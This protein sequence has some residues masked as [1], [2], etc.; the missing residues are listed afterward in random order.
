LEGAQFKHADY[1]EKCLKYMEDYPDDYKPF[2]FDEEWGDYLRRMRKDGEWGGNLELAGIS[3][4]FGVHITIHQL[5]QPRWEVRN[6]KNSFSRMIHLSYHDGQHYASVRN[7]S[8]DIRKEATEVKA[9][10]NGKKFDPATG[11]GVDSKS[12][13]TLKILME[14]TG[15]KNTKFLGEALADNSGDV[16]ATIEYLISMKEAGLAEFFIVDGEDE[17]KEGKPVQKEEKK[18]KPRR[19]INRNG[20]CHCGSGKKYKTCCAK[21]DKAEAKKKRKDSMSPSRK[22]KGGKSV[23]LQNLSNKQRKELAK[24]AKREK[25]KEDVKKSSKPNKKKTSGKKKEEDEGEEIVDLGSL[26]I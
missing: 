18:S 7:L 3:Q 25:G 12:D 15:C 1:R 23:R 19:K 9:F 24:Q 20:P 13:K 14:S 17:G 10:Q 26:Q 22:P 2:V 21:A 4:A 6:P 8:D 11:T 16:D 5:G